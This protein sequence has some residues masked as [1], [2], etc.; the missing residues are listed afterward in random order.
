VGSGKSSLLEC[1]L[2]E[3]LPVQ[4][5]GGK[6]GAAAGPLLRGRVAYCSQVPWIVS[7]TVRVRAH[8]C[9]MYARRHSVLRDM[10]LQ[11]PCMHSL[12]AACT[13]LALLPAQIPITLHA[14]MS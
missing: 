9:P 7:G 12:R 11:L 8:C 6:P 10:L 13:L 3:I 14:R 1:L 2:G 4:A 5:P